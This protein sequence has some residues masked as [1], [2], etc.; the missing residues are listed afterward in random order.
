MRTQAGLI[1]KQDGR[2]IRLKLYIPESI[3][4]MQIGL[5]GRDHVPH[6]V[7]MLFIFQRGMD[8]A[9]WMK[10]TYVP[11]SIAF[12]DENGR[13][14]AVKEGVPHSTTTVKGPAGSRYVL[15][16]ALKWIQLSPGDALLID[17]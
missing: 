1:V 12:L 6:G 9:I 14:L 11:L 17:R 3:E 4:E 16:T 8:P 2:Q 15:E 5:S 10:N 7:G 13:A